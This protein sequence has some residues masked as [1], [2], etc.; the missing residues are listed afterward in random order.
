MAVRVICIGASGCGKTTMTKKYLDRKPKTM[1]VKIYDPNAE[2]TEYYPE[3]LLYFDEFLYSLFDE[4]HESVRNTYI[5]FE[6]A[7][8]FFSNRSDDKLMRNLLV[9]ARHTGNIIW[10]NFH[11]FRSVP[12]GIFDLTDYAIIFKT[13]DSEKKVEEKF[14]DPGLLQAYAECK[15]SKDQHVSRLVKINKSM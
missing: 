11:S 7:T 14:D 5:V 15:A 3:K 2:F 12:L 4:K 1:P 8:I 6:E 9:R 10:L 13:N